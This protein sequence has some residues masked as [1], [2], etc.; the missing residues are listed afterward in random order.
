MYDGRWLGGRPVGQGIKTYKDRSTRKGR[1]ENGV[2][3]VIGKVEDHEK[4]DHSEAMKPID[5][6][7]LGHGAPMSPEEHKTT[8]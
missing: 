2:F 8:E 1:W 5:G 3:V 4:R 6:S 7:K